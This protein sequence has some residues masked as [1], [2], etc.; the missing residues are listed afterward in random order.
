MTPTDSSPL[1]Q[2]ARRLRRAFD[3][4]LEAR[5]FD[6][7]PVMARFPLG[8][9]GLV[10]VF[11]SRY[12]HDR[13]LGD[14]AIVSAT[15]RSPTTGERGTHAW[16]RQ[17]KIIVDLTADQF[18]GEGRPPVWVAEGDDWYRGWDEVDL[19]GD[20]LDDD[21]RCTYEALLRHVPQS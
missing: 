16:S 5:E 6:G 12:L 17:D 3:A 14:W 8:A 18:S 13:N 7:H 9:C 4:A 20:D 10:S 2:A 15:R 11:A 21:D 1:V 19:L